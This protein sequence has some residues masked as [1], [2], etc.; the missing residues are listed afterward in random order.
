MITHI[1]AVCKNT[2]WEYV[3]ALLRPHGPAFRA[4]FKEGHPVQDVLEAAKKAGKELARTGKMNEKT[5][6]IISR[7][8]LPL[9]TYVEITNANFKKTLNKLESANGN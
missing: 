2:D 3:G 8:L 7:E 6:N 5:L 9:E 1:K 4:M